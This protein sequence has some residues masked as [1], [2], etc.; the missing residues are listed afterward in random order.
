VSAYDDAVARSAWRSEKARAQP[1]TR[2]PNCDTENRPD[3]KDAGGPDG[4]TGNS[5]T[6]ANCGRWYF[7]Y[8]TLTHAER[9]E[10]FKSK[11]R[12]FRGTEVPEYVLASH[13]KH[14]GGRR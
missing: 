1:P 4:K 14:C 5:F 13:A 7:R 2:C 8:D 12:A 3:G 9:V 6:C 11:W 10:Q